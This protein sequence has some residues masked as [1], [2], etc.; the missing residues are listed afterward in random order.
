MHNWC[1]IYLNFSL[2]TWFQ[3][4]YIVFRCL[5]LKIGLSITF[6]FMTWLLLGFFSSQRRDGWIQVLYILPPEGDDSGPV[7]T[8]SANQF[9]FIATLWHHSHSYHFWKIGNPWNYI[10]QQWVI[11]S[12]TERT[13]IK[14][15]QSTPDSSKS[16][17]FGRTLSRAV[18]E[19]YE[20]QSFTC[21]CNFQ[22]WHS[23]CTYL[24]F[25]MCIENFWYWNNTHIFT[26]LFQYSKDTMCC[27]FFYN[28]KK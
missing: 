18:F 19:V 25:S 6:S 12:F 21:S 26:Y 16:P 24:Q 15:I 14:N 5:Y 1:F 28:Q 8:A 9:W 17:V 3:G 23:L 4:M 13:R 2:T 20:R 22:C 11:W 27:A 10:I 7:I